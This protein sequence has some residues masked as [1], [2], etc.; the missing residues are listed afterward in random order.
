MTDII[1][2]WLV[3]VLSFLT[4]F[5]VMTAIGT[6]IAPS[7]CLVHIRSPSLLARG[8]ISV[9]AIVPMTG[10]ATTF[11]FGLTLPEK[12]G[13]TLMAISP[14][15]PLALRRALASGGDAGF[16]STLQV[17]VV[18]LAIPA[19]PMWV[20]FGN[21]VF[22]T[23]G[24]VDPLAIARQVSLAQLLPL[25]SGA[26]VKSVAPVGSARVGTVLGRIGTMLLIA[27]VASVLVDVHYSILLTHF[28]PIASAAVTTVIAISVGHLLGG[29]K[30]ETRQAIATAGALRNVG[31]ALLVPI[32]D[33]VPPV[34]D[35]VI[36]SYAITAIIFV[37]GYIVLYRR[38]SRPVYPDQVRQI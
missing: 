25:V 9:L 18:I 33:R 2:L 4:V 1:P 29:P 37:T 17:A 28:W 32:T 19:V 26:F 23:N 30:R 11:A 27:A 8:L 13:V 15:A 38:V 21:F 10:I 12:V 20:V 7:E 6:T 14:G 35:V 22:G 36:I 16:A 31:V 24:Y 34:V 5:S 3:D